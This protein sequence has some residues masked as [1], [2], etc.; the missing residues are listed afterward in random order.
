M[1][2]CAS[3]PCLPCEG[4]GPSC[5]DRLRIGRHI[6]GES[7]HETEG[8]AEAGPGWPGPPP[9]AARPAATSTRH[10]A[11]LDV[12][13]VRPPRVVSVGRAPHSFP[14]GSI[15]GSRVA[16]ALFGGLAVTVAISERGP[17]RC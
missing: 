8:P 10:Q 4:Y 15:S 1:E 11:T 2:R 9:G 12:R 13:E 7:D 3:L 14:F 6:P 17:P 5:N 16:F